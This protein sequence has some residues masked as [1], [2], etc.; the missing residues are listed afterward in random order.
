MR[1]LR[2]MFDGIIN[3]NDMRIDTAIDKFEDYMK[4][5]EGL[6]DNTVENYLSDVNQFA[7][8]TFKQWKQSRVT[9]INKRH[10]SE[11]LKYHLKHNSR[12]TRNRKFNSLT[13]FF[14]YLEQQKKIRKNPMEDFSCVKEPANKEPIYLTKE[15]MD[16]Y[17]EAVKNDHSRFG[18]RNRALISMMLYCGLRIEEVV[19]L[20]I[21]NIKLEDG[22]VK[23]FGKGDKERI[24]PLHNKVQKVIRQYLKERE[25]GKYFIKDK[26]KHVLFPSMHGERLKERQINNIVKKYLN[27]TDIDKPITPHKLRHSFASLFYTRTKDIYALKK[28]L[29]HGSIQTT[30]IYMHTDQERIK[31]Q[32]DS[33]DF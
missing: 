29:G 16:E 13:K 17:W 19:N 2:V 20:D 4:Y 8:F 30:E 15:E 14:N 5:E 22:I 6:S 11:F 21:D 25:E 24:V 12:A 33:V 7:R 32:I 1:R 27:Q 18:L 23:F 31:K 3:W 28:L 10:I 26:Y 9:S